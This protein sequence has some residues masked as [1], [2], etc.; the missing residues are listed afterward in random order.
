MLHLGLPCPALC[1]ARWARSEV[2]KDAFA[3]ITDAPKHAR[4]ALRLAQARR[5]PSGR[6]KLFLGGYPAKGMIRRFS[7][8]EINA[9]GQFV[10]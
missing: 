10:G 5:F 1:W 8:C 9:L 6:G 7:L 4:L 2:G 3:R